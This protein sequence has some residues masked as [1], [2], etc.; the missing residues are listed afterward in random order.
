MIDLMNIKRQHMD[1]A[2][3]YDK[4]VLNVLHSGQYVGGEEVELF[5]KEFSEYIGAQYTVSCANGTDA[6]YIALKAAGI[7]PGD[8]VVTTAMSFF[9]T[10]EAIAAVGAKPVF[11]DI[12]ADTYCIDPEEADKAVTSNTKAILAV[13]FYGQSC[14]MDSL[15]AVADKHNLLLITDCAQSAGTEYNGNRAATLGDI[16]CFSFY[17]TKNLGGAGDGGAIVANSR[18]I[19]E[20]CRVYTMH[21]AGN[22]SVETLKFEMKMHGVDF[23]EDMEGKTGKYYHYVIAN[24]SRLDALQA[25]ILRC[26]L[27]HMDEFVEKRRKNAEAYNEAFKDSGYTL[28]A[29]GKGSSHSYYIYALLHSNADRVMNMLKENGVGTDVYY[30]VP[31]HLQKAFAYLGYKKGDFPNAEMLAEKSFAIP[32]YPELTEDERRTVIGALLMIDSKME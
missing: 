13:H 29:E 17:P 6:L 27:R 25:A 18:E 21:G 26:K 14:D 30:P 22:A 10:S 9:A 24:N 32:V 4:A 7:G 15:R 23:P 19:A 11:A 12:C 3:E 2:D 28:P 31:L 16:A 1:Y 5:E 8:D 20:R